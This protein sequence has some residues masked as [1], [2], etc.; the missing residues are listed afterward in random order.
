MEVVATRI[1]GG[2][3]AMLPK[4]RH[5]FTLLDCRPKPNVIVVTGFAQD[6]RALE[7]AIRKADVY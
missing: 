2:L 6:M 7:N 1:S 5:R 3:G 4:A